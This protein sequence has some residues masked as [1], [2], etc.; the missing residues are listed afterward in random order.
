MFREAIKYPDFIVH[1]IGVRS[2][3]YRQFKFNY[4]YNEFQ[5]K[6]SLIGIYMIKNDTRKKLIIEIFPLPAKWKHVCC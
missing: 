6:Y 2:M 3:K 5:N 4:T 1:Q